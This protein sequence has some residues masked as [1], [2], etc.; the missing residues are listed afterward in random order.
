MQSLAEIQL[1]P[2][3]LINQNYRTSG[4]TEIKKSTGEETC[5]DYANMSKCQ[6][7]N[8]SAKPDLLM[9][10]NSI[11]KLSV[12]GAASDPCVN[13][14]ADVD[15][16]GNFEIVYSARR[17]I[18]VVEFGGLTDSFPAFEMYASLNGITKTL[19]RV[20]PPPGNTVVNLLGRASNPVAGRAIFN[21]V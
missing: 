16:K 5:F 13:L 19:F 9:P 15:Y 7:N 11:T 17:G 8:F 14:A 20:P 1:L 12:E 18:V 2:P 3:A 6:F 4:T 21:C 10:W